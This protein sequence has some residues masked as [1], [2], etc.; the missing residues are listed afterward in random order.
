MRSG[1]VPQTMLGRMIG[2]TIIT[3]IAWAAVLATIGLGS[4]FRA[5]EWYASAWIALTVVSAAAG[6]GYR[7][8]VAEH[9]LWVRDIV[10]EELQR[11]RLR[12]YQQRL[13]PFSEEP[14][15]GPER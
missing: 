10:Q 9:T 1:G 15:F 2:H 14:R 11:A 12:R 3:V 13:E 5:L 6:F 4:P 7:A 8:A